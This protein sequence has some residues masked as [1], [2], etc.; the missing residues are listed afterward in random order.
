[1][2]ERRPCSC[3][4]DTQ[5]RY[6]KASHAMTGKTRP[7]MRGDA[8]PARRLE[9]RAKISEAKKGKPR[10]DVIRRNQ[11]GWT[12]EQRLRYSATRTRSW[13]D[14]GYS[15]RHN[16]IRE[17]FGDPGQ[18]EN[19]GAS[20]RLEWASIE[21][22]YTQNREDW[23]RLCARCHREMDETGAKVSLAAKRKRR[24]IGADS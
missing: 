2:A 6:V 16:W 19:C 21:H 7:E 24:L 10:P 11:Q 12:S 8:N 17:N 13:E 3:G 9:I 20:G 23:M 18:C 22:T 14:K 1:M 5:D 4:C 15:G